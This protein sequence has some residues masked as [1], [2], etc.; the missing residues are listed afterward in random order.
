MGGSLLAVEAVLAAVIQQRSTGRSSHQ[1]VGLSQAAQYLAL[2]RHWRLTTPD[3]MIGGAHA[4][5]QVMPCKDGKVAAAAL[6]PHFASRL[7]KLVG[8]S[9]SRPQD[10]LESSLKKKVLLFMKQHTC[11]EL[12][13]LAEQYD[14]PLHLL[15][16]LK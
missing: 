8:Y 15:P 10:V 6:E 14:L 5:Y 13:S 12:E 1:S 2:P 16:N 4:F 7:A 3:G 11:N 9:I